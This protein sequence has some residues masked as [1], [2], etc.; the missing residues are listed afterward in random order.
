GKFATV[1]NVE[2]RQDLFDQSF[3][4]SN[5]ALL[6]APLCGIAE[7]IKRGSSQALHPR[8][9]MKRRADPAPEFAL[10]RTASC[11]L[12]RRQKRRRKVV[13]DAEI[14]FELLFQVVVKTGLRMQARDFIFILVG[15]QLE[16]R[17]DRKSTR[18]N[19]SHVKISYA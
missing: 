6:H 17:T 12:S 19:S 7:D 9:N 11:I 18:L 15:H 3:V 5:Q 16:E 14:A 10:A 13:A 4:P 2:L 1:V 8:K